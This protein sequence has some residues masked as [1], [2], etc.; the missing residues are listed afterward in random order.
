MSDKENTKNQEVETSHRTSESALNAVLDC[1]FCGERPYINEIEPHKHSGL[2]SDFLP[3]HE[4]SCCI[5]CG[6][7]CGL[8]D[9]DYESVKKRW[10]KRAI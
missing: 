10:N 5:E 6:C 9:D 7:G 4:G 3:D 1:P 8:I 2:V